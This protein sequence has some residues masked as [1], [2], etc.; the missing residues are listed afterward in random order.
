MRTLHIAL[1]FAASLLFTAQVAAEE[2]TVYQYGMKLDIERVIN[3]TDTSHI[4]GVTPSI[5]TYADSQGHVHK[6]QYQVYGDG[7]SDN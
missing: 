1:S 5:M 7:C 3:I 4:C 6:L 2:V